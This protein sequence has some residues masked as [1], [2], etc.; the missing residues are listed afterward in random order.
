MSTF[1]RANT[2]KELDEWQRVQIE[3]AK[4]SAEWKTIK[5][6]IEAK[7]IEAQKLLERAAEPHEIY[8]LQGRI[9]GFRAVIRAFSV[10]QS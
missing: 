8:R 2:M 6:D 5:A 7:V 9:S 3:R 1:D 4:L 10:D